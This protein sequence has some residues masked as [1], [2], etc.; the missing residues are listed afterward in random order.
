[1]PATV[2]SNYIKLKRCILALKAKVQELY[3]HANQ[4]DSRV[5]PDVSQKFEIS[6]TLCCECAMRCVGRLPGHIDFLRFLVIQLRWD[7]QPCVYWQ[8]V[9]VSTGQWSDLSLL[10]TSKGCTIKNPATWGNSDTKAQDT[11]H[12]S[13]QKCYLKVIACFLCETLLLF[14]YAESLRVDKGKSWQGERVWSR[15]TSLKM[16]GSV[17]T[18]G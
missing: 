8:I 4:P 10:R 18:V 1:M 17:G 14:M 7:T 6:N 13:M 12:T 5:R 15:V 16:C 3:T 2:T 9:Q 11:R